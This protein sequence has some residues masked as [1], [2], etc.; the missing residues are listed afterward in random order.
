MILGYASIVIT[1][2]ILVLALYLLFKVLPTIGG[3]RYKKGGIKFNRKEI[4]RNISLEDNPPAEDD[5]YLQPYESGE[6]AVEY[7][8]GHITV[9][10][11]VIIF[12]FILFDIDM[13]LLFPWAFDFYALG[14]IPFVET[15]IFMAMPLFVVFY[16]YKKGYMRW[17]K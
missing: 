9:Q 1:I 14:I 11:Y 13:L 7:A 17:M 6:V 8:E 4:A 3:N 2:I 10:Y 15:L 16:A 12:L 5:S